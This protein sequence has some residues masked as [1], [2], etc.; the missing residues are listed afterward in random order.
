VKKSLTLTVSVI[1]A[2]ALGL[3]LFLRPKPIAP[4]ALAEPSY[5]PP[6]ARQVLKS[7]MARHDSQMR[8]LLSRV[9]LLDADGIARTAGEIFDEPSLARPVSGDELNGLLPAKFFALRDE[10]K[11]QARRLVIASQQR[12]HAAMADEF[13]TLAKSCITCHQIYLYGSGGAPRPW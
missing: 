11:Q 3:A 7:K 5:I 13:A 2:T 4:E 12:D 8:A 10:L 9:V 1:L 6:A